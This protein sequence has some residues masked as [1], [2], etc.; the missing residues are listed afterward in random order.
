MGV[1]LLVSVVG[2]FYMRRSND[3]RISELETEIDALRKHE[4]QSEVDRRVSKQPGAPGPPSAGL[5]PP[6]RIEKKHAMPG[7]GRPGMAHFFW[8]YSSTMC[9]VRPLM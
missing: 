3:E 7:H 9:W 2:A 4:K 5:L 1:L 6:D 8:R